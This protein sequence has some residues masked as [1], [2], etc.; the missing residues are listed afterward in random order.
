MD[1]KEFMD[2]A[3][4]AL[5]LEVTKDSPVVNAEQLYELIKSLAEDA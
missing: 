3:T 1:P 4:Y 2:E 5:F